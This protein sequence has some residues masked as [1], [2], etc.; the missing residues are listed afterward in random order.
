MQF[1]M[2]G[3]C[4]ENLLDINTGN[5]SSIKAISRQS[6]IQ[7]CRPGIHGMGLPL[8][9]IPS[10]LPREAKV[11]DDPDDFIPCVLGNSGL[12]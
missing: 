10:T 1:S 2:G 6:L 9:P 8:L 11:R 12:P 3:G 7:L 4:H 5:E